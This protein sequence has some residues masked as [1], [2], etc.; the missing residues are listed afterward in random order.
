MALVALVLCACSGPQLPWQPGIDVDRA[1]EQAMARW[2]D[3]A[4][5]NEGQ[6]L[7]GWM[8]LLHGRSC[9]LA[10]DQ[11]DTGATTLEQAVR[12]ALLTDGQQKP[13]ESASRW[14]DV[15]HIALHRSSRDPSADALASRAVERVCRLL[16]ASPDAVQ[17][18]LD[19]RGAEVDRLLRHGSAVQRMK[20]AVALAAV[21]AVRDRPES[22]EDAELVVQFQ[23][24]PL[25]R[26]LLTGVS[27]VVHLPE[28][29]TATAVALP[30]LAA[31]RGPAAGY[32]L[33]ARHPGIYHVQA[34]WH[35]QVPVTMGLV[36]ERPARIWL[37]GVPASAEPAKEQAVQAG[38]QQRAHVLDLVIPVANDGEVLW[39]Q[40][41]RQDQESPSAEMPAEAVPPGL[42]RAFA[43][44]ATADSKA[45]ADLTA[46]FPKAVLP[47]LA[48]VLLGNQAGEAVDRVLALLPSQTDAM[49]A[50][51]ARHLESGNAQLAL[52]HVETPDPSVDS[53]RP[54]ASSDRVDRH[55]LRGRA[56]AALGLTDLAASAA[57]AAAAAAGRHCPTWVKAVELATDVGHKP[58]LRRMMAGQ[59]PCGT[60]EHAQII[61]SALFAAGQHQRAEAWL[62]AAL[63]QPAVASSAWQRLLAASALTATQPP[64]PPAYAADPS[65]ELWNSY[66]MSAVANDEAAAQAALQSLLVGDHGSTPLRQ[67]SLQAGATPP[68]TAFV[69]D[70]AVLAAQA[71]DPAWAGAVRT[72]WLLDQE[73]VV[74]LPGGGAVRRV[75]QVV[76]VVAADAADDVG[77]VRVAQGADLEFARTILPD[78]SVV[79]PADTADKETISLRA[80]EAGTAIEYAQVVFVEP[81][82]PATGATRLDPFTLQAADGPTRLSEYVVLVPDGISAAFRPSVT[83]PTAEVRKVGAWTAHIFRTSNRPRARIEP[84]AVRPEL[85]LPSVQ[86][87][88]QGSLTAAVEPWDERLESAAREESPALDSWLD[89]LRTRPDGVQRWQF[90]AQRLARNVVQSHDGGLSGSPSVALNQQ[91]G[92]RAAV[93]YAL[94][95]RIG[96]PACVVR[97]RPLSRDPPLDPPDPVDFGL[98]LVRIQLPDGEHWYDPGLEGGLLDHIRSGLRGRP[99]LLTGCGRPDPRQ[100]VVPSLGQD[101][102]RRVI[103]GT[104]LWAADG[105][106]EGAFAEHLTG[107]VAAWVRQ[108]LTTAPE[109][110]R[111]ALFVELGKGLL[112]GAQIQVSEI[113]GLSNLGGPLELK[114]TLKAPAAAQRVSTLSLGLFPSELGKEFAVLPSRT[115]P[116][117]FGYG[118]DLQLTLS[119]VSPARPVRPPADLDGRDR[120]LSWSRRA[121]SQAGGLTLQWSLAATPGVVAADAYQDFA[122]AARGADA[123]EIIRLER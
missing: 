9:G 70:G 40:P 123:A 19:R 76:R 77:E 118:Q 35:S 17:G 74:L 105:K 103:N 120:L 46:W 32:A 101:Q 38:I 15:A 98:Q 112:A 94:A 86:V 71:D 1:E 34:T 92:D 72:A 115:M 56:L 102:D 64:K 7:L 24:R 65:A 14:L 80:V 18:L 91:K 37:D 67:R 88:G 95:R 45:R 47:A 30:P 39:L 23:E 106:V 25:S 42:D 82:D 33:V 107:A 28:W 97:V 69:R 116:L 50:D 2:R 54:G 100:V 44:L 73:V 20:R 113:V 99:G 12:A 89:L 84:K 108:Y 104:L 78:G 26:R 4:T 81:E 93:F 27:A 55:M 79:A 41:L 5:Q 13:E 43:A 62:A 68:W 16:Q 21:G 10:L 31:Q 75:H 11:R 48:D 6:A 110:E 121:A 83:A 63:R 22:A 60:G 53:A 90:A 122:K 59:V 49:L 111:N 117:L 119:I 66:Q 109:A 96:V 87:T 52:R 61:A 114:W 8:C 3:P 57:E 36:S 51:A 58:T 85:Q 29:V